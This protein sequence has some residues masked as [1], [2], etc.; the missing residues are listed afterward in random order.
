MGTLTELH[1]LEGH[2]ETV[3]HCAWSPSGKSLATC[4][5]DKE[6]RIWQ[7]LGGKWKCQAILE[8]SHERTIRC[9]EW[10]PCGRMLATAS[11]DA[12]ICV[13]ENIDGEFENIATLEGHENEVKSV[14]WAPNGK[15]LAS[16]GRDKSVWIWEVSD[17]RDFECISVLHEH[18][19]DVK[20][21]VWH[22]TEEMLMSTGYDD[23][24][25]LF[26]EDDDDWYCTET[27]SG[28]E[29]T[30]WQAAFDPTGNQAVTC[31][32]DK[33]I[34]IWARDNASSK[35]QNACTISGC[36]TRCV[37]SCHWSADD[38][39][40]TGA[41]DDAIRTFRKSADSS[42]SGAVSYTMDCQVLKA[43]GSDI[44]CV[45]WHP[46][47]ASVLVSGSDDATVKIWKYTYQN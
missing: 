34:R 13:W 7:E 14:A 30:V 8:D 2:R 28:H 11:F 31:S 44:N 6:V 41:G 25:K 36:H 35:F 24:A 46:K 15:L 39:I 23:V 4:G 42:G 43:H 12:T 3:W 16:S 45:R 33:T 20:S 29:S 38:V 21:V 9:C 17:T 40:V 19:Q 37:Y 47:D 1:V 18:S 5:A 27:F 32:D 22:P 26:K 10:S